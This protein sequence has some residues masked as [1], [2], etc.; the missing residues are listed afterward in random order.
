MYNGRRQPSRDGTSRMT[1][2]C[3]VRF[4]EGLGVKFPGP[5]RQSRRGRPRVP[6]DLLPQCPESGRQVRALASV[7]MG[8]QQKWIGTHAVSSKVSAVWHADDAVVDIVHTFNLACQLCRPCGQPA[9]AGRTFKDD[10][11]IGGR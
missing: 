8:Q 5:T 4:C 2:E 7:A 3:H 9:V 6:V 1:R 11:A 10:L